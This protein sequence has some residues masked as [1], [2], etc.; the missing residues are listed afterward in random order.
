MN[1]VI[2]EGKSKDRYPRATFSKEVDWK[3]T[4]ETIQAGIVSVEAERVEDA[5]P[6]RVV[7]LGVGPA[8]DDFIVVD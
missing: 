6:N 8:N 7:S 5:L 4:T 1:K 3:A 2:K